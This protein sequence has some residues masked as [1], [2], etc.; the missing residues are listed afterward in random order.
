MGSATDAASQND[1]ADNYEVTMHLSYVYPPN[2]LSH[3]KS[4]PN[5][6]ALQI[7]TLIANDVMTEFE[8]TAVA[9]TNNNGNSTTN[10]TSP[11]NNIIINST[12]SH[13]NKLQCTSR[14]S[15]R[16]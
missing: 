3:I 7:S 9:G 4:S 15:S 12:R 13:P 8:A 2:Y 16:N 1:K 10:N 14:S 11:A 6:K 5:F